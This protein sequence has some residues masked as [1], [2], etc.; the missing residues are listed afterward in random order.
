MNYIYGKLV[1]PA[2]KKFLHTV[3]TEANKLARYK[4]FDNIRKVAQHYKI[5]LRQAS[6]LY[7]DDV[8]VMQRIPSQKPERVHNQYIMGQMVS[9][10]DKLYL[11]KVLTETDKLERFKHLRTI[12][13]VAKR[14]KTSTLQEA[15]ELLKN[16]EKFADKL[17]L[18]SADNTI[19]SVNDCGEIVKIRTVAGNRYTSTLTDNE[20]KILKGEKIE[21]PN[22]FKSFISSAKNIIKRGL[23]IY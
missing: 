22:K 20:I 19:Y 18:N 6:N 10:S 15:D 2:E 7:D 21:T 3:L 13:N 11:E 14:Y 12:Q 4:H 17:N 1:T 5:S 23:R 9:D 8:Y 16:N